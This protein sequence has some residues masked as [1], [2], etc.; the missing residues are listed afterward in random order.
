LI[1]TEAFRR[2]GARDLLRAATHDVHERL[3]GHPDLK[4][5]AEGRLDRLEYR[6]LLARLHGFHAAADAAFAQVAQLAPID[7]MPRRKTPLL[8]SDLLVLGLRAGDIDA[9]PLCDLPPI[10]SRA[11]LMGC[12]Y[13]VEGS[14]LGG[15]TLARAVAPMF[16]GAIAGRRFLLGYGERHG[17]MW[18]E[19]LNALEA[20]DDIQHDELAGAA[21]ATFA[22]FERWMS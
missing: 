1:R 21:L 8:R 14:T 10:A 7:M 22:A 18:R 11:A 3:H 16:D 17:A 2:P 9:L 19:F 5:L 12:A 6:A 13:V 20:V 4:R 15:L